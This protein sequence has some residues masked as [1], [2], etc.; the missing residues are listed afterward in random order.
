MKKL[1]LLYKFL[2]SFLIIFSS[3]LLLTSCG[4]KEK[5]LLADERY[6]MFEYELPTPITISEQVRTSDIIYF[7]ISSYYTAYDFS[8][9]VNINKIKFGIEIL[10]KSGLD[11]DNYYPMPLRNAATKQYIATNL[12]LAVEGTVETKIAANRDVN[13]DFYDDLL[14]TEESHTYELSTSNSYFEN[15][16]NKNL[17]ATAPTTD[18]PNFPSDNTFFKF[19]IPYETDQDTNGRDVDIFMSHAFNYLDF[20]YYS[21]GFS[22]YGIDFNIQLNDINGDPITMC[23]QLS[24]QVNDDDTTSL[25]FSNDI[26]FQVYTKARISNAYIMQFCFWGAETG[27]IDYQIHPDPPLIYSAS[28]VSNIAS[29]TICIV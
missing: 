14:V 22:C 21:I 24:I 29:N 23:D 19:F 1:N 7:D 18:N 3:F 25:L 4:K 2:L 27:I 5:Q 10:N 12:F 17:F 6:T 11:V 28:N 20:R 15:I 8:F 16:W 26:D 13:P 9:T